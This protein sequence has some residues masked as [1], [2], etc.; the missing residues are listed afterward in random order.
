MNQRAKV[1]CVVVVWGVCAPGFAKSSLQEEMQGLRQQV[2]QQAKEI[3]QLLHKPRLAYV[4]GKVLEQTLEGS[5]RMRELTQKKNR[6]EQQL[7][8][9]E[10]QLKAQEA[11]LLKMRQELQQQASMGMVDPKALQPKQMEFQQKA[12]AFQKEFAK[13]QQM[14]YTSQEQIRKMQQE[15][16]VILKA[17]MEPVK[18]TLEKKLKLPIVYEE[19]LFAPGPAMNVTSQLVDAYNDKYPWPPPD[20]QPAAKKGKKGK[21]QLNKN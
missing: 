16:S 21:K 19:V 13:L 6:L 14:Q 15:F 4:S 18:R 12:E 10:A 11:R 20:A 7:K 9:R 1:L 8:T 17:K 5:F 3:Q 2:Q